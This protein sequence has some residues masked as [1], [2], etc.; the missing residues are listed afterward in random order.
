M[1]NR[2]PPL[3]QE[4]GQR[5]R[6]L[7]GISHCKNLSGLSHINKVSPNLDSKMFTLHPHRLLSLSHSAMHKNAHYPTF[8]H[9]LCNTNPPREGRQK[10]RMCTCAHAQVHNAGKQPH[11]D[12]RRYRLPS[13]WRQKRETELTQSPHS[14]AHHNGHK[15]Q[16]V[17]TAWKDVRT[18]LF[19]TVNHLS[20]NMLSWLATGE[21]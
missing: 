14:W 18:L 12:P 10:G 5:G 7:G 20:R 21:K 13:T 17:Q 15:D 6:C 9:N 1:S 16:A 2:P 4:Q 8:K 11:G 3:G 19:L